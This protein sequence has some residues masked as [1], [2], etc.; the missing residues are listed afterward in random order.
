MRRLLL[1][2]L[3][4]LGTVII[5]DSLSAG[6]SDLPLTVPTHH[7]TKLAP[8]E[9]L[10][11]EAHVAL[12][13]MSKR[14]HV[15]PT[16]LRQQWQHVAQCEVAGNWHMRGPMYSGIGFLNSTWAG[17]GGKHFAA[18][19]GEATIEE[20]ILVGMHVTGGWVPDQYGCSPTGW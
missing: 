2:V 8:H 15:T 9:R 1:A 19:A 6:A 20:Q 14:L 13:S 16:S 5:P 4:P 18:H 11:R 10:A 7:V 12:V 3:L 17:Y